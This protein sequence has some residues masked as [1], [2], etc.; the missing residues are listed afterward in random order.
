MATTVVFQELVEVP[1]GIESFADFRRWALSEQ[2]PERGRIDYLGGRI[3]V[4]MSPEDLFAHGT[5]KGEIHAVLYQLVK[6]NSLGYCFTDRARVSCPTAQVSVEPD[7]VF[8]STAAI[9]AGRVRLNPKAGGEQ[10]RFVEL[11]GPP[12]LIVEI[13]SDSSVT[14]DTKRLPEHYYRAG[15]PEF[16]LVDARSSELVFQIH[17]PGDDNDVAALCDESGFQHSA[18]MDR[19]FRLD[20]R[21]DRL[22][23]WIYDLAVKA[24]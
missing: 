12:D 24:K 7:V 17:R 15:V 14:K 1:L 9:Q 16:W 13:V 3:E 23:N 6:Q 18:V 5:P 21:M 8:V 20:R 22:R 19:L 2:F 4:D 11:E 10:G